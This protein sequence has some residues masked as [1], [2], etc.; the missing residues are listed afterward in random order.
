MNIYATL[1]SRHWID[2]GTSMPRKGRKE[3]RRGF[4]TKS[5]ILTVEVID[6]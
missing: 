4:G 5:I 3:V 1:E 2:V 6:R